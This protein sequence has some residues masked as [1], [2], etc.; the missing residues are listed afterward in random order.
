MKN[1]TKISCLFLAIAFSVRV[2]GQGSITLFNAL[3]PT[4]ITAAPRFDVK[5]K[6]YAKVDTFQNLIMI[7]D[8]RS[9][10]NKRV[11]HFNQ[12]VY[13][14]P[15]SQLSTNSIF[16]DEIFED[17]H[18]KCY[19]KFKTIGQDTD[20]FHYWISQ[21]EVVC[22]QAMDV[23]SI[24]PW[25]STPEMNS[26][27]QGVIDSLNTDYISSHEKVDKYKM[28]KIVYKY[29]SD[30]VTMIGRKDLD[31]KLY[32]DFHFVRALDKIPLYGKHKKYDEV[33][34]SLLHL[35]VRKNRKVLSKL[36]VALAVFIYL[37]ERG[38][39]ESIFQLSNGPEIVLDFIDSK[40]LPGVKNGKEVK[41]TIVLVR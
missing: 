6:Y 27:L 10:P 3:P 8:Y 22:I 31:G 33:Y 36:D 23:L 39:V 34:N 4:E 17:D 29:G 20:I 25:T 35:M 9:S 32:N 11:K 2:N 41:T 21:Q 5:K 14:V 13:Q 12:M 1:L 37:N 38:D 28:A 30:R 7:Y 26:I 24:G 40:F 16:I 15:L 19:L 18:K